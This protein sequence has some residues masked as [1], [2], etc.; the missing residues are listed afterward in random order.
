MRLL[1]SPAPG[2]TLGTKDARNEARRIVAVAE[3]EADRIVSEAEQRASQVYEAERNRSVRRLT[4]V[5]DEF[6]LLSSRLRA[7]KE[8]TDD[9][10]TNALRDHDAIRRLFDE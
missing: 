3:A 10:M 9:M 5:R 4:E 1:S 2:E 8:A 7:L 6:E